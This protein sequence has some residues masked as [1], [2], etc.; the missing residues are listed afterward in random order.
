NSGK[1][2][3][4]SL[5]VILLRKTD[6]HDYDAMK[7]LLER[8]A[9]P[10]RTGR[11]G[12]TALHNAVLSDNSLPIIEA[13]LDHGA[14]PSLVLERP[15]GMRT[16]KANRSGVWMRARRGRGDVLDLFERRGV[17][18]ELHGVERLIA[19][20]ARNDVAAVRSI[21]GGD[22]RLID[23]LVTEGGTLLAQFAATGN[24]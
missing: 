11:F 4:D 8:G 2:S 5:T 20:C 3:D 7:W 16:A 10:N 24:T 22:P 13:L 12:K 19:A 14:D 9:D 6:W 18:V 15:D 21:A 23:E 1:L 17:P